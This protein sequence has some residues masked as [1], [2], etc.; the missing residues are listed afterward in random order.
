MNNREVAKSFSLLGKLME[1]HD[2]SPFKSKSYVNAYLSI[3]KLTTPV[4]E[5]EVEEL[6]SMRGIGK[7]ITEKIIELKNT[8]QLSLLNEY[9]DMT[10]AGVVEM[11]G[12]KGLGPKKIK[13]V[14]KELG[15]ESP[16]ELMYACSE[17]RLVELSGF[18]AKTQST[19]LKQLEYF[20]ESKGKFL[21]ARI[22][23][24]ALEILEIFQ[25]QYSESL[26]D[27][28]GDLDRK[29]PVV[30]E[31]KF[32]TS[33][34]EEDINS[35][36]ESNDRLNYTN[37]QFLYND[38]PFTLEFVDDQSFVA[39]KFLMSGSDDFIDDILEQFGPIEEI[40]EEEEIFDAL[41]IAYI[42]SECRE[43]PVII[44]R[45]EAGE[46]SLIQEDQIKGLIHNHSTYSDGMNSLEDM[47]NAAKE[48][49]FEYMLISD[50]SKA[51][52]YANGLEIERVILQWAEIDK[53]NE[54]WD[55]FK[56]FKGIE[57]DILNDGSLDYPDDILS[58][59][60]CVISS[61]HTNLKMDISKAM[62]RLIKAIENPHTRILG[63]PTGRLLLSREGYPIDHE[64][65]ID[66][67]VANEV[68][69]ELNAN[70]LRLDIDWRWIEYIMNKDGM[71]SINPDAHS[72][73]GI[74]DIKY[75]VIAARK[76]G[77][78]PEYCLN[79]FN[80]SDF[81]SWI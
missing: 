16:G 29:M 50:H 53:L 44:Q 32:I 22:L 28:C 66:A 57:S 60:D 39:S 54:Q 62:A 61:V 80:L 45:A 35:F 12:I 33:I 78:M 77:L 38:I 79:I 55:D 81:E 15:V 59:F 11:L 36:I 68:V 58:G 2:E 63:H 8:G 72:I 74:D 34:P 7:A 41:E 3:R 42:P 17:N 23:P 37:G 65:I 48:K 9:I 30:S 76:G 19:V 25:N 26:I 13:T 5:M 47:A 73:D 43:N 4:F 14:W 20:M 31:L 21:Y 67:C 46:L 56:I 71:I 49:G 69:I 75:G 18:G 27:F 40:F 52:F 51:A 6:Q 10:P 24:D 64:K 70:P 1:L